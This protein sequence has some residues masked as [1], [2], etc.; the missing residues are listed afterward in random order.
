MKRNTPTVYVE[1]R[2]S[3]TFL[4]RCFVISQDPSRLERTLAQLAPSGLELY[5]WEGVDGSHEQQSLELTPWCQTFCPAHAIGCGLAHKRLAMHLLTT[6]GNN[7]WVLICEDDVQCLSP[8]TLASD[9]QRAR[10]DAPVDA[11]MVLLYSMMNTCS[12]AGEIVASDSVAHHEKTV[13]DTELSRILRASTAVYLLSRAGCI[14]VAHDPVAY[15]IDLQR[16]S[17]AYRSYCGPRLFDTFDPKYP[18]IIGGQSLY[19]ILRVSVLRLLWFKI[20]VWHALVLFWGCAGLLLLLAP[21]SPR[22]LSHYF[23]SVVGSALAGVVFFSLEI[24]WYRCTNLTSLFGCLFPLTV[25]CT[26]SYSVVLL[27]AY[28]ML[29]FH[30]MHLLSEPQP[31]PQ[32]HLLYH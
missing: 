10:E 5:H 9:L 13:K 29:T 4:R 25:L 1:G 19:F 15:H 31:M 16:N 26:S 24:F 21:A 32:P 18:P 27:G 28:F 2:M 20:E 7:E 30:V 11:D 23:A 3:N 17:M 8:S 14:K 6:M 22:L 12:S